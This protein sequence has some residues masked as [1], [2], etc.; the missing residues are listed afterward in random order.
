MPLSDLLADTPAAAGVAPGRAAPDHRPVEAADAGCLAHRPPFDAYLGHGAEAGLVWTLLRKRVLCTIWSAA[1]PIG[2]YEV[3]E[4]LTDGGRPVSAVSVYRCLG[5]F[6][7][8]GLV[9][10]IVSLKRYILSPEPG[11]GPWAFL[12]CRGCG[13]CCAVDLR[14]ARDRLARNLGARAFLPR[15]YAVEWHGLCRACA[16]LPP[17]EAA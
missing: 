7:E 1:R 3:A 5:A 14:P 12:L 9:V 2:A 15:R 6:E 16:A 10:P 4:R 11:A 13:S 17:G 8:A